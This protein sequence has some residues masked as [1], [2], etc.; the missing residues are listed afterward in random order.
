MADFI[1]GPVI[2]RNRCCPFS[3][4]DLL[5]HFW[6]IYLFKVQWTSYDPV[7]NHPIGQVGNRNI[8]EK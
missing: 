2:W 6:H 8:I 3:K 1:Q 5:K 4:S 7:R